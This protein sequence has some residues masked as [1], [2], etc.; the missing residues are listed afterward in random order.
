MKASELRAQKMRTEDTSDS[1]RGSG[2]DTERGRKVST[3]NS[4]RIF[5]SMENFPGNFLLK[6]DVWGENLLWVIAEFS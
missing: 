5:E 1:H 3:F 2:G 4:S 6:H